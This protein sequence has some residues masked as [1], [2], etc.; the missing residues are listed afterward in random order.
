MC[1]FGWPHGV[2][3]GLSTQQPFMW[4]T[5]QYHHHSEILFQCAIR[6]ML[7]VLMI[8]EFIGLATMPATQP[9]IITLHTIQG[10][11]Q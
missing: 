10:S 9:S 1:D 8:I 4:L 7:E 3:D 6:W 11:V 2:T 5:F